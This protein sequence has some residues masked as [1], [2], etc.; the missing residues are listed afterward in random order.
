MLHVVVL[1]TCSASHWTTVHKNKHDSEPHDY[2]KKKKRVVIGSTWCTLTSKHIPHLTQISFPGLYLFFLFFFLLSSHTV[3]PF[4]YI[5]SYSDALCDVYCLHHIDFLV[6][7]ACCCSCIQHQILSVF[8]MFC[9]VLLSVSILCLN[10]AHAPP[11]PEHSS[12]NVVLT[13]LFHYCYSI[14]QP[15]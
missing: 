1:W 4:Y 7:H 6:L 14:I 12:Q 13:K 5:C 9:Y 3:G 15:F 10:F 11:I 2:L 8:I